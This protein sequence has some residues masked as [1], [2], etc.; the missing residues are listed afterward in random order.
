M[1][2]IPNLALWSGWLFI[3]PPKTMRAAIYKAINHFDGAKLGA[4]PG[5][6]TLGSH[7]PSG[8]ELK[9]MHPGYHR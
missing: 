7:T 2:G 1:Q 5:E 6:M 4:T 9:D 8:M 3:A